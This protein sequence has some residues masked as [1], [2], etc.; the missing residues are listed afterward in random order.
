[1]E[2]IAVA[3]QKGGVGKTTT[4]VNLAACLAG[5]GRRVLLLDLDSQANV[6]SG[7]GLGMAPGGGAYLARAGGAERW[8]GWVG[9]DRADRANQAVRPAPH[10]ETAGASRAVR[11]ALDQD[12]VARES[13]GG[14]GGGRTMGAQ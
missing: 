6:T 7:L 12:G 3:N 4:A 8:R 14:D 11:A 9:S 5:L 2:V 10:P 1:M 13:D